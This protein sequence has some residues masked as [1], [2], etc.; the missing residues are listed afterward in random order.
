MI[1]TYQHVTQEVHGWKKVHQ[2]YRDLEQANE[3]VM[4]TTLEKQLLILRD[5][6]VAVRGHEWRAERQ[7]YRNGFY[8]LKHI[9]KM[10]RKAV[11]AGLTRIYKA[12]NRKAAVTAYRVWRKA[13]QTLYP[14]AV[15]RLESV[16]DY[17]LNIFSVPPEDRR[18][19]RTTNVI[20]RKT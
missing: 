2:F 6:F 4:K 1:D 18:A 10:D 11:A 12:P 7:G 8:V 19:V 16:L 9:R 20:E 5:E 14:Q 13:W 3:R 15:S 17:L